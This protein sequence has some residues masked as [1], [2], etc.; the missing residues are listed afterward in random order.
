MRIS[1]WSAECALPIFGP[2]DELGKNARLARGVASVADDF[3]RGFR[4]CAMQ[5]PGRAHRT[6]HV[7][8]TLDD[9]RRNVAHRGDVGEQLVVAFEE[10]LV[11]E[12]VTLDSRE[13]FCKLA[14]AETIDHVEVRKKFA[15]RA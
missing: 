9:H 13:G 2:F 1:D 6:D 10:T 5:I 14:V 4:P 8:A 7:V 3:K 15:G 11:R 12:I